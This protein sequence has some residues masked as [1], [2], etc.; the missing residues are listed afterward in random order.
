MVLNLKIQ[1]LLIIV[2]NMV[3]NI[4][5]SSKNTPVE[6]GGRAQEQDLRRYDKNNVN[7]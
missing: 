3:L 2:M 5:F 6:W 4:T 1:V 7:C